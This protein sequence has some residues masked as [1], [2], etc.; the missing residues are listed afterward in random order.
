MNAAEAVL[1]VDSGAMLIEIAGPDGPLAF[2]AWQ[3]GH[4][5][6]A[7]T[8]RNVGPDDGHGTA[9]TVF[10]PWLVCHIATRAVLVDLYEEADA[11]R[12]ADDVSRAAGGRARYSRTGPVDD[13][14]SYLI[15]GDM[16][17][18]SDPEK[19]VKWATRSKLAALLATVA[20][21]GWYPTPLVW[22][23]HLEREETTP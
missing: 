23:E 7:R 12:L 2:L 16:L 15:G 6:V 13:G 18:T 19:L 3:V 10:K 4:L 21:T 20:K 17:A 11:W 22:S 9:R 8:P 14:D 5:A 1:E